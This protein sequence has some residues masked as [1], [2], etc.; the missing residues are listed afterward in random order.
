MTAFCK[1]MRTLVLQQKEDVDSGV[2]NTG[3]YQLSS[4]LLSLEVPQNRWLKM[5]TK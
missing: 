2:F 1:S 4:D 3:P 5:S